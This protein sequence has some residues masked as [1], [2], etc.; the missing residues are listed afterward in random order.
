MIR[1]LRDRIVVE[2][3]DPPLS[4][5]LEVIQLGKEGR[6]VL[7]RIIACGPKAEDCKPGDIIHFTDLFKFPIIL[8]HGQKRLILQEA[9][10]A[11]I[12]ED[13]FYD[14]GRHAYEKGLEAK[15]L[16]ANPYPDNTNEARRF[17]DGWLDGRKWD[18]SLFEQRNEAA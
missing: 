15:D 3:L 11:G 9:D 6:H 13:G 8:D 18:T 2:P 1:P 12:E 17:V 4:L 7:G 14:E 5:V 16:A 10:I